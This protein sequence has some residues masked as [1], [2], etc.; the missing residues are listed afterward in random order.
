M[1]EKLGKRGARAWPI[2]L[3]AVLALHAMSAA[4]Q[5]QPPDQQQDLAH[6]IAQLNWI[7]GPNTVEIAGVA[8]IDI[9]PG[10]EM[11]TPPDGAKFLA[12]NGNSVTPADD[13]SDYILQNDD[14]DSGWFAILAYENGGH[15]PDTQPI[16]APQ[17]LA[18]MQKYSEADNENRRKHGIL[19]MNLMGWAI[20]PT[21]NPQTHRLDWAFDFDNSDGSRTVNLNSR[22]LGRDGDLK[23]IVVDDPDLLAKDLPDFN[24]AISGFSFNDGQRYE[25]FVQGDPIA[26]YGLANLIGGAGASEPPQATT[27]TPTT[28]T[29]TTTPA[30][31]PPAKPNHAAALLKALAALVIIAIIG[32][33]AARLLA[34]RG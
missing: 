17:L 6:E 1:L 18:I 21:Y 34:R 15:I 2:L 19:T 8:G 31:P 26:G 3:L 28:Q 9:P 11:L 27:P 13:A 12:L 16:D 29:A 7:D 4:A 24:K 5:G 14:P 25:D 20:P 23:I 10:Y 32:A 22:I 33:I 30:P